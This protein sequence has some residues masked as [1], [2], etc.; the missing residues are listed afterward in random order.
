LVSPI[1]VHSLCLVCSQPQFSPFFMLCSAIPIAVHSL[2]S[3]FKPAPLWSILH[4]LCST[5]PSLVHSLCSVF[6][7]P[8]FGPFFIHT[9]WSAPVK[10]ILYSVQ[11]VPF[12]SILMLCSPSPSSVH[13]VCTVIAT[14]H[15][16]PF[17]TDSA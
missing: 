12:Q 2:C 14:L 6:S 9:V 3:L 7:Q 8:L 15:E 13:S 16:I 11:Q 4:V 10:S 17:S 1:L 5:S